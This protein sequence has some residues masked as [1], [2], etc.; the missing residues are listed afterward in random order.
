MIDNSSVG[1]QIQLFRKHNGFTQDELAEKLGISAQAISKWENG[2][3]LPET[4][5]LPLLAE[6]FD[7]SI[8]SILMPFAKQN[9]AFRDFLR[10]AGNESRELAW[11]LYEKMKSKFDLTI[12]YNDEYQVYHEVPGGRSARFEHMGIRGFSVRLDVDDGASG[13]I[14][15]ARVALP[16]CSKYMHI[17]EDMPEHIKQCFRC[18]DCSRCQGYE[19]PACMIYT[20]EGV[21]YRQCHF[22]TISLDFVE[23]MKHIF[24]LLCAEY[25]G[26]CL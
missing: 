24:T 26:N 22:I 14:I 15:L 12:A 13:G 18:D 17:I 7:C 21:D 9:S 20:F 19:C 3:T 8:D 16:N 2:H 5:L 6:L 25:G 1:K 23:N 11:K 4:A 10:S